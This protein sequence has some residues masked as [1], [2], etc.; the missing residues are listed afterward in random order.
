MFAGSANGQTNGQLWGTVT[1]NWLASH[2]LSYEL[3]L[4]PKTLVAAPDS[5]PGWA[6]FDVVPNVEYAVRP[7]LD[8]LGELATGY[9]VQ[10]D[11]VD[12]FEL[13]PRVGV[14]FHMTTRDLPTGLLK[15]EHLPRHRIV[16]RDLVR[17]EERVLFYTGGGD[18]DAVTRFRNRLE[19]QVPLNRVRVT[20]D[21]ARYL[22]A[23]WE[24]FI[25]LDDPDERF[26]N[27]QRIRAGIGYRHSLTWRFEALYIWG[28]SR[29]TT[30]DGFHTSDHIVNLRVK[31][32]F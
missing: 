21:G 10:T 27:R 19:L 29:D 24:W 17:L 15:R 31:R 3:E 20:D 2:R 4:E 16:V 26:A 18:T 5:E 25:P 30:D 6:S 32:V 1:F 8:V 7:W 12:S 28:R 13:S 23:D 9:T 22:L 11:D 14:R